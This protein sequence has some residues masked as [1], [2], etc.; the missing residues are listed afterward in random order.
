MLPLQ[1]RGPRR[2]RSCGEGEDVYTADADADDIDDDDDD[3][4]GRRRR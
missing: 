1:R 2:R 3:G 4:G